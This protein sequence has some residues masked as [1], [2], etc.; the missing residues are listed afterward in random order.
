LTRGI[1]SEASSAALSDSA[2]ILVPLSGAL[3][4]LAATLDLSLRGS[5]SIIVL[6][7]QHGV[8]IA[9]LMVTPR[10]RWWLI[11]AA[12]LPAH[13]AACWSTGVPLW[14]LAWQGA[15]AF[16]LATGISTA[17]RA[18]LGGRSPFD[19]LQDF[20]LYVLTA[21]VAGPA[22]LTMLAPS[23]VLP[24]L[25]GTVHLAITHWEAE[26]IASSL[27]VLTWGSWMYLGLLP[28][29]GWLQ[30]RTPAQY[31]EALLIAAALYGCFHLTFVGDSQHHAAYL[32]FIPLL[33]L[34]ARFGLEAAAM[35]VTLVATGAAAL[36]HSTR[37][38]R[39]PA[40]LDLQ[41]FLVILALTALTITIV[42]DERRRAASAAWESDARNRA[43]VRKNEER[44]AFIARAACDV[45]YEW[46]IVRGEFWSSPC[47]EGDTGVQAMNMES[48]AGSIHPSDRERVVRDWRHA[49]RGTANT[50]E[51]EYLYVG[52]GGPPHW[53]RHRARIV[54]DANGAAVRIFG[55]IADCSD[56]KHLEEA[57]RTLE[58]FARLAMVG[59]ITAS[60]AHEMNQPLGAIR[61]NAEAGLLFLGR[62]PY[63][64]DELHEIFDDIRRDNRRASELVGRLRELL[65]DR[66]LRLDPI[67][68]NE[69][70]ADV[71]KL[72]R[73]ESRQRRVQLTVECTDLPHVL[74]DYSRLQQ[75]LLNLILNA[76]DAISSL[77]E[78]HRRIAIRSARTGPT[79]VQVEVVDR[80]SGI[81]PAALPKIFDSFFTSK[82]HGMGL[83]LAIARSIVEA[84]GGTIWAQNNND[85]AGATLAFEL[86]SLGSK[87]MLPPPGS[88][89]RYAARLN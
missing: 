50:W 89:E 17:L 87:V 84:H 38:V 60:I 5:D 46:D 35:A 69:V 63:D 76:M 16:I 9:L 45:I 75:V 67:D 30:R 21:V 41:I 61:Y 80:G 26:A 37:S 4:L 43:I 56:R 59:Q 34:S 70:I 78:A 83:G 20:S 81:D 25:A 29:P 57:N 86:D 14:Q 12:V 62:E 3:Y 7:P 2:A 39:I 32:L 23:V 65:L 11:G 72:L 33:W 27:A 28:Q 10:E 52:A 88:A 40:T 44:L 79:R 54:R 47:D 36:E 82:A 55:A 19:N 53:V 18:L 42:V 74:G 51:A 68:L 71:V 73:V 15:F 85:G 6:S 24:L 8:L 58:R 64:K 13:V 49:V 66:E 1:A 31:A 48:W 77:P 22:L